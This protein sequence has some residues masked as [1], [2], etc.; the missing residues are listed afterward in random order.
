MPSSN[1]GGYSVPVSG[2][3]AQLTSTAIRRRENPGSLV[4]P[5]AGSA[6]RSPAMRQPAACRE[7]QAGL[8]YPGALGIR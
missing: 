2:R 5:A 4:E 3:S 1:C 8:A 7:D 6:S